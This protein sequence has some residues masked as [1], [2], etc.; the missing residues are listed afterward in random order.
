MSV[1]LTTIAARINEQHRANEAKAGELADGLLQVGR[2][3]LEAK[4]QVG[5]GNWRAWVEA[6][7]V[8]GEREA[9]RYMKVARELPKSDTRV[10]FESLRGA[11]RELEPP[12]A[13]AEDR[14]DRAKGYIAKA[15]QCEREASFHLVEAGRSGSL[16]IEGDLQ[17]FWS[18]RTDLAFRAVPRRHDEGFDVVISEVERDDRVDDPAAGDVGGA[19]E[20][21]S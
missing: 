4:G 7:C 13:T 9:Q 3:L 20:G 18:R 11:L 12:K 19:G 1:E 15:E 2:M 5:H 8:F 21:A 6:N 14:L 16:W 17:G 10:G